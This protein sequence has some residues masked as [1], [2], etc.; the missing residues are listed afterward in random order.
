MHFSLHRRRQ[1]ALLKGCDN[2]PSHSQRV[3][4]PFLLPPSGSE[5]N[6]HILPDFGGKSDSGCNFN[7]HVL[8]CGE[9]PYNLWPLGLA[10]VH[11]ASF[12]PFPIALVS[13]KF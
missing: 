7:W 10:F 5:G 4:E 6:A 2:T 9:F 8:D 13:V 3:G 1:F 12:N 11:T